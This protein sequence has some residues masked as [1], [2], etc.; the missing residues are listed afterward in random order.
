MFSSCSMT[1]VLGRITITTRISAILKSFV[2]T[3]L[4]QLLEQ[5][6]SVAKYFK[7]LKASSIFSKKITL[8]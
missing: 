3:V 7:R 1:S 6:L 4:Q 2:S 8:D 5:I